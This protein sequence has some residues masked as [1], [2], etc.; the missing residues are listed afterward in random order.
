MLYQAGDLESEVYPFKGF[1]I[2]PCSQ[3]NLWA[4][5]KCWSSAQTPSPLCSRVTL[6]CGGERTLWT[7]R[8][9]MDFIYHPRASISR[10][11]QDLE[12]DLGLN[13]A[14]LFSLLCL[15]R[16]RTRCKV[17]GVVSDTE[18]L[19]N[20]KL[21]WE[22]CSIWFALRGVIYLEQVLLQDSVTFDSLPWSLC[23]LDIS[24]YKY[25]RGLWIL[26]AYLKYHQLCPDMLL[27]FAI[28]VFFS[29]LP[30]SLSSQE[31]QSFNS[32]L[33]GKKKRHREKSGR[34]KAFN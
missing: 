30:L 21:Y 28:F 16:P 7:R 5:F 6:D 3:G 19:N 26:R 34:E 33:K 4:A 22:S 1:L 23:S 25:T 14:L 15:I 10:C 29:S 8:V 20:L 2:L 13:P 31:V 27:S 11:D 32:Q 17:P 18:G 24:V 9:C 12:S